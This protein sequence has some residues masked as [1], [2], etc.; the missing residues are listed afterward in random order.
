MI[1]TTPRKDVM[2]GSREQQ[3]HVYLYGRIIGRLQRRD[4]LTRFVFEP[5]YWG[6]PGRPVLGLRFEEDR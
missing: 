4:N 5:D 2:T 1:P 6:D 3:F